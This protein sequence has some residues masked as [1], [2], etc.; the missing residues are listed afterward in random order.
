MANK[1]DSHALPSHAGLD[2]GTAWASK[3]DVSFVTST[4]LVFLCDGHELGYFDLD[5]LDRRIRPACGPT[6]QYDSIRKIAVSTT[7]RVEGMSA[8]TPPTGERLYGEAGGAIVRH[9]TNSSDGSAPTIWGRPPAGEIINKPAGD[10]KTYLHYLRAK[11]VPLG[12][13]GEGRGITFRCYERR[14][15]PSPPDLRTGLLQD[16]QG[17]WIG[18]RY[19]VLHDYQPSGRLT[20]RVIDH[21]AARVRFGEMRGLGALNKSYIVRDQPASGSSVGF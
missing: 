11:P 4:I 12:D 5:A 14:R 3:V 8:M 9:G 17:V 18:G 2:V 13:A 19:L 16:E 1:D 15:L 6:I 20:L 10:G 21:N 7:T